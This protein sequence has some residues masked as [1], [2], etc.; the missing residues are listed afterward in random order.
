MTTFLMWIRHGDTFGP[1]LQYISGKLVGKLT[2]SEMSYEMF[3]EFIS[4]FWKID[5]KK[6]GVDMK[7]NPDM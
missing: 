2:K 3:K 7:V 5:C 1:N 6:L 4:L